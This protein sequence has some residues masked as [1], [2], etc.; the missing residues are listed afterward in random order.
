MEEGSPNKRQMQEED[1]ECDGSKI[2]SE[3]EI[4][5]LQSSLILVGSEDLV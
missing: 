1:T 4:I 5:A 3:A 2:F